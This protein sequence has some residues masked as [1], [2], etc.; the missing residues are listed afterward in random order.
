MGS[1]F[2]A[3]GHGHIDLC[4]S[5]RDCRQRVLLLFDYTSPLDGERLHSL[6]V[7]QDHC[8]ASHHNDCRWLLMT[9]LLSCSHECD[10]LV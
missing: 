3:C 2:S 4:L 7:S 10:L 6:Q 9:G 5:K 8:R 1:F